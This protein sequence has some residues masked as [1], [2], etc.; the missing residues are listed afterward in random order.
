M[1]DFRN[2]AACTHTLSQAKENTGIKV[3][4]PLVLRFLGQMRISRQ[5]I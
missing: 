2:L 1:T 5:G 3:K 4:F